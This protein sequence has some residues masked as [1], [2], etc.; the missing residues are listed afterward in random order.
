MLKYVIDR[1]IELEWSLPLW[2]VIELWHT[3]KLDNWKEI[4]TDWLLSHWYIRL[5]DAPKKRVKVRHSID[6]DPLKKIIWEFVKEVE[7]WK[8][9]DD[10]DWKHYIYETAISCVCKE[11]FLDWFNSKK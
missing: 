6:Y 8:Y 2:T 7:E 10:N 9:H 11:W 5:L 1:K 3:C 4:P